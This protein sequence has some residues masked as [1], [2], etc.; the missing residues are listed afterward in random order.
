MLADAE[1][2]GWSDREIGRQCM[3]DHKT[4]GALRASLANFPSDHV[5]AGKM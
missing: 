4:V 1:W 3:V 2:V 5:T